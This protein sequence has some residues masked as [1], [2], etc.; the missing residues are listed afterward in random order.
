[1]KRFVW[2]LQH[3]LDIRAKEEQTKRA[4]LLEITEK[5]AE[6]RGE[7]LARQTILRKIISGITVEQHQKRLAEQEFFLKHS[8]TSD[9]QIKTLKDKI[10]ELELRQGE[11][12]AEVLKV[13]RLKEGLE[14]LR[15]EAKRKF[16]REQEKLEQKEL[17]EMAGNL[18]A[19]KAVPILS[20]RGG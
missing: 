8:T 2:R 17:D 5:L 7:L 20:A 16:I 3:V 12:I 18:F 4:E 13:R 6:T 9:E 11:K 1:M 14:K 15:A 10:S 19:R